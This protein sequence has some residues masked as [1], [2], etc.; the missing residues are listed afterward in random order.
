MLPVTKIVPRALALH[1][2]LTPDLAGITTSGH[3]VQ[4]HN[5]HFLFFTAFN[6]KLKQRKKAAVVIQRLSSFVL[7]GHGSNFRTRCPE[8]EQGADAFII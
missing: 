3:R 5:S 6:F 1:E 8:V 2:K 7:Q 4:K